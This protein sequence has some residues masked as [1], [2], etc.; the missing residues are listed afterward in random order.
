LETSPS[1]TD[2]SIN[3]DENEEWAAEE[4]IKYF[5]CVDICCD[6]ALSPVL[7]DKVK[8]FVCRVERICHWR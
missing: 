1:H 4:L 6:P 5:F 3:A 7:G 8:K 2:G